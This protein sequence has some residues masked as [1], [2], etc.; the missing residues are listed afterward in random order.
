MRKEVG[1]LVRCVAR[2]RR[3]GRFAATEEV[4]AIV[5]GGR[6][7]RWHDDW[8]RCRYCFRWRGGGSGLAKQR[9]RLLLLLLLLLRH[10]AE[11]IVEGTEGI[12]T[13]RGFAQRLASRLDRGPRGRSG[14]SSSGGRRLSRLLLLERVHIVGTEDVLCRCGRGCDLR[15]SGR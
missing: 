3:C 13:A 4:G 14:R 10:G 8:C 5:V 7:G 15:Q 6:F 1:R 9:N 11:E 2:R 12:G